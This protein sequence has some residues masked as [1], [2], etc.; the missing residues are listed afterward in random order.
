MKNNGWVRWTQWTSEGMVNFGQMPVKDVGQN[1]R[2]FEQEAGK[3][4]GRPA[5]PMS[6]T[7]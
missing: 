5:R 6:C 1:L 7:V 2:K 4:C 3:I